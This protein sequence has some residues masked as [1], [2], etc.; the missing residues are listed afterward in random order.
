MDDVAAMMDEFVPRIADRGDWSAVLRDG[1]K[2]RGVRVRWLALAV[3]PIAAISVAAA[4]LA[5]PSTRPAPEPTF[6][7]RAL[8]A[9]GTGPVLHS[10]LETN[11][12]AELVNLDTG[13]RRPATWTNEYWYDPE[14]GVRLRSR[15][16]GVEQTDWVSTIDEL[17]EQNKVFVAA[18]ATGYADTL[19]DGKVRVVERGVLDGEPVRWIEV[20]SHP[21]ITGNPTRVMTDVAV[22]ERTFK[23]VA[24]RRRSNGKIRETSKIR[25]LERLPEG[26]GD[27][28]R[29]KDTGLFS[30][31][32]GGGPPLSSPGGDEAPR[33]G[34]AL[35]RASHREPAAGGDAGGPIRVEAVGCEPGGNRHGPGRP[36][37]LLERA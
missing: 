16:E 26:A 14:D 3:A 30:Y 18:M 15:F 7:E 1:G 21:L 23:P 28:T 37:D 20:E 19:A 11:Y 2:R 17:G 31:L 6:V 4:I 36:A 9:V 32:G 29:P 24:I 13:S 8:A 10:V 33:L 34:A 5:W 27:F 22:S 35:G 25:S 12:G